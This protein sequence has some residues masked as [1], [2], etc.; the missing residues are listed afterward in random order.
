MNEVLVRARRLAVLSL[1]VTLPAAAGSSV[2]VPFDVQLPLVLKALTY[3]RSLKSRAGDQVRIAVLVP[4]GAR[5]AADRLGAALDGLPDRTVNGLPVSFREVSV[6]EIGA[7]E[8]ALRDTR[9]VVLYVLPGFSREELREVRRI[10]E[11]RQIL[12]V[13]A[14]ADEVERGMAFAIGAEGGK[15]QI[16]VNVSG[17]KACGSE[18]ELALLRVSRVVQ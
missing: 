1:L 15:P 9:W 13:A 18:F 6:S 12:P 16:V 8:A 11:A 2:P 17:S 10:S 3:D 5:G 4:K 14:L 7:L